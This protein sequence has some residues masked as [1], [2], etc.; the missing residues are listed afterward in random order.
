MLYNENWGKPKT[1]ENPRTMAA[2][3]AWLETKNPDEYYEYEDP[4]NCLAAQYHRA[5][6]MNYNHYWT[7]FFRP[8][9]W[10]LEMIA[11]KNWT[12]GAAL[13]TAK[14]RYAKA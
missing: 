7:A 3:I 4:E 13:R 12:F 9:N 14:A 1:T 5:K 8:F 10:R 6:G 11:C 2:V